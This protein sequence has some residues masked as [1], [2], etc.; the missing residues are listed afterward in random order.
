MASSSKNKKSTK[1]KAVAAARIRAREKQTEKQVKG[2][3]TDEDSTLLTRGIEEAIHESVKR[4]P[5]AVTPVEKALE[6]EAEAA[7]NI[8]LHSTPEGDTHAVVL[9]GGI[10]STVLLF[11]IR[12]TIPTAKIVPVMAQGTNSKVSEIVK[13]FLAANDVRSQI[14]LDMPKLSID[15]KE[16]DWREFFQ[17]MKDKKIYIIHFAAN[18]DEAEAGIVESNF[19]FYQTLNDIA[20]H[21]DVQVSTPF[22][23]VGKDKIIQMAVDLYDIHIE[24]L[25]KPRTPKQDLKDRELS[26]E[27]FEEL[28]KDEQ[29]IIKSEK[30]RREGFKRAF[31]LKYQEMINDPFAPEPE[32][33][34]GAAADAETK[35]P[36]EVS[37]E[38][39]LERREAERKDEEQGPGSEQRTLGEMEAQ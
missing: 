30:I 32:N 11:H 20:R 8:E 28:S 16:K 36:G 26:D 14:S 22:Q 3:R 29:D 31:S 17:Q 39:E 10:D 25:A 5:E 24:E 13:P 15:T 4:D 23:T 27:E 7:A 34:G 37:A 1:T 35:T 21:Y 33:K 9:T 12:K 6:N 2:A 38:E 18:H 19:P